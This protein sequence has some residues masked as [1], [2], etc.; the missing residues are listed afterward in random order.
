MAR[1]LPIT[2]INMAAPGDT[3]TSRNRIPRHLVI[4]AKGDPLSSAVIE[5]V[6]FILTLSSWTAGIS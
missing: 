1:H 2:M 6:S 4:I 5:T 3:V